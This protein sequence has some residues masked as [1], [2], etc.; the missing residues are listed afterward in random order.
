MIGQQYIKDIKIIASFELFSE[1]KFYKI[2][3]SSIQFLGQFKDGL[4]YDFFSCLLK[5]GEVGFLIM[6]VITQESNLPIFSTFDFLSGL[7]ANPFQNALLFLE[8]LEVSWLFLVIII[9]LW[10]VKVLKLHGCVSSHPTL[11][12]LSLSNKVLQLLV[13]VIDYIIFTLLLLDCPFLQLN[14]FQHVNLLLK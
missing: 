14:F 13:I 8:F 6:I 2:V 7:L 5:H 10:Y 11:Y 9:T 12:L 4:I 1:D 3:A